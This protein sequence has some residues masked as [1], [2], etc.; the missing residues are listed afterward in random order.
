MKLDFC[1]DMQVQFSEA[2]S[3][4]HYALMCLPRDTRRQRVVQQ[5]LTLEP[6]APLDIEEDF[7][8][9]QIM[10]GQINE[11][12]TQFWVRL[13]GKVETGLAV[14]EG[15]EE[16]PSAIYRVFSKYTN[17]GSGLRTF[18]RARCEKAPE[19]VY[20]RALYWMKAVKDVMQYE[21]GVTE[22]GTTAEE[23]FVQKKGVCQDFTHIFLAL[24][25]LDGIAARYVV[26]MMM[27]EGESHA[28]AEV[29][30]QGY[31]YGIDPTNQL[32][33]N[34]QYIKISHGRDSADCI[35]SRGIF[36]GA[37]K[38]QQTITVTVQEAEV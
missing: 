9:N 13:Q 32:L 18:Y 27:G 28:W 37:A 1:Y 21:A 29:N 17:P 8:G 36:R 35:V 38:Q 5:L 2:V 24:L 30:C 10:R 31:W 33:V 34:D 11:K 4:H 23:A 25:R 7:F 14:H 16:E 6:D 22:I 19:A 3:E 20:D 26:G 12:H 15:Y